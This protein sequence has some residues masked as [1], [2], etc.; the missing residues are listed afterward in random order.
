MIIIRQYVIDIIDGFNKDPNTI[1]KLISNL[2][3]SS[4]SLIYKDEA[5]IDANYYCNIHYITMDILISFII[6][7]PVIEY[8]IV[9]FNK[10]TQLLVLKAD[11]TKFAKCVCLII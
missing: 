2:H 10:V 4:S 9:M 5:P 7:I 6:N 3:T 11:S 1:A 8:P